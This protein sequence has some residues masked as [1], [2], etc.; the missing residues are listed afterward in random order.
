MADQCVTGD[1]MTPEGLEERLVF[2]PCG[3]VSL[4]GILTVPP[5][6]NGRTVLI[7]WGAG[8][9]PSSGR[10][11][12]RTRLARTLAAEGFHSFRFDYPGVGE[13][14]GDFQ[15]PDMA[16]PNTEEV[17]AAC[18]W[19]TSQGLGRIVVVGHCFG[20]WSS[21]MAAP[22]ILGLEGM[23]LVNAPVKKDHDQVRASWRWWATR[24]KRLTL[25]KLLSAKHRAAYR[26]LISAHAHSLVG[27]GPKAKAS[28]NAS[29][30]ARPRL[31]DTGF[32]RAVGYLIDQRIPVLLMYDDEDFRADLESEL[33]RGLRVAIDQA[34]PPTRLVTVS[35]RLGVA[36]LSAQAALLDGIVPWLHELPGHRHGGAQPV[37]LDWAQGAAGV[38]GGDGG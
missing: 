4:A 1:R 21:L 27:L 3:A 37:D 25:R 9:F 24:L 28:A 8:P 14:E 32:S 11:R 20:A 7:P 38:R 18:T 2:F 6:P 35:E 17:V 5:E 23:A 10:N 29:S 36:G 16:A 33:E 34:G 13:S 15:S 19:L 12:V 26:R 31:R 22:T 30:R